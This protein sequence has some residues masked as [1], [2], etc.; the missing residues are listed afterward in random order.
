[1]FNDGSM[2]EAFEALDDLTADVEGRAGASFDVASSSLALGPLAELLVLRQ[3]WRKEGVEVRL[4]GHGDGRH[5]AISQVT[6]QA[7]AASEVGPSFGACS[8]VGAG[9]R[10]EELTHEFVSSTGRMATDAG[11]PVEAARLLKG[12]F[13][14]LIDNITDHAG[15]GARGLAAYEL[16]MRSISL[17]VADSGR[18]I[19]RAYLETQPELAGLGAMDALEWAV[20]EHRSRFNDPKR[21]LGFPSVLNAS[22]VMDAALRVR[23]DE[24]SIEV[25]GPADTSPWFVRDQ[26]MLSGFVVSLRLAWT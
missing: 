17:V 2:L 3:A 12:I 8:I 14:E 21:G 10:V 7:V 1:V 13:G 19:V 16:G 6:K 9:E 24:G 23:S 15:P 22:R 18:G 26:S 11:M 5:A 25:E 20:K 4:R